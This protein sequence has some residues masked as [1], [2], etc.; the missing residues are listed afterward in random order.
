MALTPHQA[1][2]QL[3]VGQARLMALIV[4]LHEDKQRSEAELDATAAQMEEI[5]DS[6]IEAWASLVLDGRA[7]DAMRD[8]IAHLGT[9][10]R[11]A[12]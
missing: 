6:L 8:A 12:K 7:I 5:A 1:F 9:R 10:G 3:E 4:N 11:A 2:H